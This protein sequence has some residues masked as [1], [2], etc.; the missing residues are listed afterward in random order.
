MSRTRATDDLDAYDL[1]LR[2]LASSNRWTKDGNSTALRYFYAAIERDR[3]FSTP[4]GLAA[5]CHFFNKVNN[6]EHH[7]DEK[8]IARLVDAAAEIGADDP[9]AL[10]WAGHVHAF[11][12]KD[13]ER[14][15]SLTNRALELDVN[16][17]TAW[18]RSGW[19]RAYAGD[20]DGAIESLKNTIRLDPIDPRVFMTFT[21]MACAHFVGGRDIE[22]AES[23]AKALRLKPNLQPALRMALAS[24]GILRRLDE[25]HRVL[26]AYLQIDPEATV[27]KICGHYPFRRDVDRE[28]L[29]LGL[30]N[31]GVPG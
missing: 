15:L 7:F 27:T 6:W 12:F 23:A 5:S 2:G 17:A 11:F 3:D 28:R 25:A 18:Q 1:Y 21:A 29:T 31:A 22:A 10:S 26:R 14:G 30:R 4:Y 13:V 16:L 19:V 9:V 24:N 8:E 20:P